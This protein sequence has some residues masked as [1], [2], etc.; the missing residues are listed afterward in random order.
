MILRVRKLWLP[1]KQLWLGGRALIDTWKQIDQMLT[2]RTR[3]REVNHN[4]ALA[5]EA[6]HVS[7]V[8]VVVCGDVDVVVLGPADAL[9]VDRDGSSE[10]TRSRSHADDTGL[11]YEVSERDRLFAVAQGESVSSTEIFGN[12]NRKF[13]LAIAS[14]LY[15]S[16]D[17]VSRLES[18]AADATACESLPHELE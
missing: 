9:Q 1:V 18:V 12:D 14:N 16:D 5:V 7:H 4:V 15:F 11:D 10:R 6:A 17:L 2:G 3:R 8:R 13:D